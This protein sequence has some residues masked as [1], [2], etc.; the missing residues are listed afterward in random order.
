M[1]LCWYVDSWTGDVNEVKKKKK[2]LPNYLFFKGQ[3][4]ISPR[5]EFPIIT[6]KRM[7]AYKFFC[8]FNAI[9]SCTLKFAVIQY[10]CLDLGDFTIELYNLPFAYLLIFL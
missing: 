10:S 1:S 5:Y 6:Y 8:C 7:S 2:N 3:A 9:S 4:T